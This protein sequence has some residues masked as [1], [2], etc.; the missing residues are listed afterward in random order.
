[1]RNRLLRSRFTH[2][3]EE[4]GLLLITPLEEI[5]RKNDLGERF[6]G[7]VLCRLCQSEGGLSPDLRV[8]IPEKSLEEILSLFLKSRDEPEGLPPSLWD[9]YELP[10]APEISVPRDVRFFQGHKG[11]G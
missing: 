7:L 5:F 11:S 3:L 1:M 6:Y 2:G 9:P 10:G 8:R 4:G